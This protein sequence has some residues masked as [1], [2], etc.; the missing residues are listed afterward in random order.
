MNKVIILNHRGR[1]IEPPELLESYKIS[2]RELFTIT[3]YYNCTIFRSKKYPH[4]HLVSPAEYQARLPN[5]LRKA[6]LYDKFNEE[7]EP[8]YFVKSP[9]L[10]NDLIEINSSGLIINTPER[11]KELVNKS[12]IKNYPETLQRMPLHWSRQSGIISN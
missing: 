3:Q 11:R 9:E 4:I 8:T 7:F 6:K 5:I 10:N 12:S 1:L 2:F